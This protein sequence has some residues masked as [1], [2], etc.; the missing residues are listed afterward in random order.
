MSSDQYMIWPIVKNHYS[1]HKAANLLYID[2]PVGTGFSHY[3]NGT[4][5]NYITDE[6]VA[7]QLTEF[8]LQFMKLFP[9]Y[10]QN[11][12]N[13]RPKIYLFGESYGGTY[14]IKLAHRIKQNYNISLVRFI[15]YC[16]S[17]K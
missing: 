16:K 6:E 14:V 15:C 3:S 4:L 9:Y 5:W 1:W 8:L 7:E 12:K 10:V 17:S 2:N 13:K 11:K